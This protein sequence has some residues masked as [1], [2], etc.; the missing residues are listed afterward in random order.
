MSN[1]PVLDPPRILLHVIIPGEPHSWERVGTGKF[2]QRYNTNEKQQD[3]FRWHLK[4]AAPTLK[5]N[6]N[7]RL[8]IKLIFCSGDQPV[9]KRGTLCSSLQYRKDYDNLAKFIGDAG[10]GIIWEDDSQIDKA[11]IEVVRMAG[12][13]STEILVYELPS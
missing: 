8:G 4:A 7:V 10:N 13:P 6:G 12:Q 9:R 5:P 3:N 11:E 2:G 1:F